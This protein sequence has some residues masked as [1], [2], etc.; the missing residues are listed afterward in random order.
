ML[1]RCLLFWILLRRADSFSVTVP[2]SPVL[3]V[4]GATAL[5]PCE[6][7]PNSNALVITWQREEDARVV[8]SFYYERDQLERQSSDYFN[9]TKLN[10]EE[11][12]KGNASL[13]IASFGLKDAG[14]YLCIVSNSKG[15]DR[16]VVHLVYTAFYSEP[17]LSI[18]LKSTDVTVQYETEG[19]PRPEVMWLGSGGQN[20]TDHLEVSSASDGG[21]F[22]LKSSYIAQSPAFNVTFTLKNPAVHQKLQ[23]HVNVSYDGNMSSR[24]SVVVLSVLCVF[25]LCSTGLLLWLYCRD[26][27]K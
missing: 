11:F 9:R 23:R 3:V 24:T 25:L 2:S 16:G 17:R 5:L 10:H 19:Y 14:K 12:T 1:C 21:L 20:L 22:Y 4:R 6:F 18:L 26:G 27:R 15:S 7:E 8:H 13:S